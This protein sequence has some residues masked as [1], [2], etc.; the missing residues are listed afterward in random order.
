[1]M[2]ANIEKAVLVQRVTAK[3]DPGDGEVIHGAG[4]ERP[5]PLRGAPP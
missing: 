4:V 5:N 3:L 2:R 1:M